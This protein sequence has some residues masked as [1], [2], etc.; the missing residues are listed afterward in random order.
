[1]MWRRFGIIT[2]ILFAALL[3]Q[4]HAALSVDTAWYIRVG[5]SD[6]S[7]AR[8][9]GCTSTASTCYANQDGA[10]VTF[11]AGNSNRL[12][13]SDHTG[14]TYT[15]TSDGTPFTSAMVDNALVI[16]AS[17]NW[18]AGYYWVKAFN[19]S[20]SI[21]LDRDPTNGSNATVGTGALGGA[22]ASPQPLS[23]TS[24]VGAPTIATPLTEGHVVY[25]Q[26]GGSA[27]PSSATYSTGWGRNY[28]FPAGSAT[29]ATTG[30]IK[31]L[32]LTPGNRWRY[33]L[34][35]GFATKISGHIWQGFFLKST[36]QIGGEATYTFLAQTDG[37]GIN[38]WLYDCV[39][40]QNGYGLGG[41]NVSNVVGC[42]FINSGT[43][44]AVRGISFPAINGTAG[45]P[46]GTTLGRIY[47]NSFKGWKTSIGS[48]IV[49]HPNWVPIEWN[50]FNDNFGYCIHSGTAVGNSS[51][52]HNS[53]R[54]CSESTIVLYH[55]P[56]ESRYL[57]R[58]NAGYGSGGY[59][60]EIDN[61]D[62]GHIPAR[63]WIVPDY[64]AYGGN[65]GGGSGLNLSSLVTAG[66]HDKTL[67]VEP[68][69]DGANGD[70]RLNSL[71]NG[72]ALL[73]GMGWPTAFF[74][75]P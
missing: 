14:A 7:G 12:N 58:N 72:G 73:K 62:D 33:D 30:M 8:S 4:T 9:G 46:N 66:S 45:E 39:I 32:P 3:V 26:D 53:F 17:G 19:S 35:G 37:T 27:T 68:W 28:E 22:F 57:I 29:S 44:T 74:G 59:F 31:W 61:T 18:T 41:T 60:L 55:F 24:S 25:I 10:Q 16:N 34:A 51:I 47:G 2:T 38:S 11:S 48:G 1:M 56:I 13:C 54:N 67:G 63:Y 49:E 71:A 52:I 5:G 70:F 43:G 20:S 40:D 21:E 75:L 15:V 36:G 42:G 6:T 64:N 65:N 69:I 50:L 23:I